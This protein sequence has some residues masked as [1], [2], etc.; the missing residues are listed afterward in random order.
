MQ[1]PLSP[2]LSLE[3][4]GQWFWPWAPLLS[5]LGTGRQTISSVHATMWQ[6]LA[7]GSS[8]AH[9]QVGPCMGLSL[10]C[11]AFHWRHHGHPLVL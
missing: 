1:V 9:I 6:L 11:E 5:S 2:S 10:V 8:R 7:V 3:G 4:W